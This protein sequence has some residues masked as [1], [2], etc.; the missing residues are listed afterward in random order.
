M[1]RSFESLDRLHRCATAGRPLVAADVGAIAYTTDRPRTP[2]A[3]WRRKRTL[4]AAACGLAFVL[5]FAIVDEF[6]H[7]HSRHVLTN[8]EYAIGEVQR[9]FLAVTVQGAGTLR[10]AD[11]RWLTAKATG[12]LADAPVQIG[13][14]ADAGDVIARL[15]NPEMDQLVR[16]AEY[17]AAEAGAS[18][19]VLLAQIEDRKLA[20]KAS[21]AA[22]SAAVEEV[23]LRL[24]AEG[25]LLEKGAI[26]AITYEAT[27]IRAEQAQLA[28]DIER[29]RASQLVKTT[30]AEKRASEARLANQNLAYERAL[31]NK[32]ALEIKAENSGVVQ[33]I[34]AKLGESVVSGGKVAKIVDLSRLRAVARVPESYA[35][36]LSAGQ[37]AEVRVSSVDVPAVVSRVD[38]SVTDGSVVVDL[39]LTS[40]LPQG[41]RPDLSI[42]ATIT[43]A[44]IEDTLFVRRPSGAV[45]DQTTDVFVLNEEQSTAARKPVQFGVGMLSHVQVI[46]GLDEGDRIVLANTGRFGD[47]DNVS[48]E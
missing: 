17:S 40:S 34:S 21:L 7:A 23:E 14:H 9:G 43:V 6:L 4:A 10:P 36:K 18:H 8:G 31:D 19:I 41:V 45:D 38:P 37:E 3:W 44:E 32:A 39:E 5:L 12:V 47:V 26:S 15:T 2:H 1:S 28:L 16:Q 27:R 48:I 33:E 22:A 20:S 13:A 42:R 25:E 35:S 30:E 24:Q 29:S 11:E 46:E